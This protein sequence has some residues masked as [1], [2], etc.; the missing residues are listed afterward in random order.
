MS[1]FSQSLY[2]AQSCALSKDQRTM[3]ERSFSSLDE[4][5]IPE[6]RCCPQSTVNRTFLLMYEAH[7]TR[8]TLRSLTIRLRAVIR[9]GLG[10]KS[11]TAK[12]WH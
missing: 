2:G 6:Y 7:S 4:K 5:F 11:R 8:A 9:G 1:I 12:E 3:A 10:C